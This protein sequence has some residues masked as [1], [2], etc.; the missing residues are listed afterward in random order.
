M[1]AAVKNVWADLVEKRLWPV[2][3]ALVLALVAA[4]VLLS[5]GG[6]APAPPPPLPPAPTTGSAAQPASTPIKIVDPTVHKA[7]R[8]HYHDPFAGAAPAPASSG[9]S[10]APSPSSSSSSPSSSS[11]SSSSPAPSSSG[12]ASSSSSSAAAPTVS[13]TPTTSRVSPTSSPSRTVASTPTGFKA[14]YRLD[15]GFGEA[16]SVKDAKD[17]V[18]L[19][20]LGP[21]GQAPLV[22]YLGVRSDGK[23]AMFLLDAPSTP[24]GDGKCWP[25]P[26]ACQLLE[27]RKG[28]SEFFD[29][30]TG[31]T[32]VVQYELDVNRV[33]ER[34]D[35]S[36]TAAVKLRKR[37][38]KAGRKAMFAVVS[39]G[40]TYVAK[41]V[42]VATRGVLVARHTKTTS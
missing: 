13:A 4:P 3:V 26:K 29:V 31:S 10:A 22:I 2:A 39:S 9:S 7:P 8:G 23:T 21:A 36:H 19:K 35:P 40:R 17:V 12:S 25:T 11:P 37:E 27:L 28:D 18:R 33:A 14:G 20:T 42:Y 32:G 38:S 41:L 34:R 6:S 1:T 30:A 24:T 5:R 16:G 15:V